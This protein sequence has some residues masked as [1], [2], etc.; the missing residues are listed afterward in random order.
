MKSLTAGL[1]ALLISTSVYAQ[2]G[3]ATGGNP[4][5]SGASSTTQAK[6][7]RPGRSRAGPLT[8]TARPSGP[9][10]K[11]ARSVD[12]GRRGSGSGSGSTGALVEGS[13]GSSEASM[14]WASMAR[15][16]RSDL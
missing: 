14:A 2:T 11:V 13:S 9:R 5:A 3:P 8:S 12:S 15:R 6:L 4:G 1:A 16:H 7:S 10:S